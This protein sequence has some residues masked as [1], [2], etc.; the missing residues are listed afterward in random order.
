MLTSQASHR[1]D[2]VWQLI[3]MNKSYFVFQLEREE[4]E[5]LFGPMKPLSFMEHK[6]IFDE[7]GIDVDGTSVM[8][9]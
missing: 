6:Q 3:T 9:R 7:T 1:K 5:K 4:K 2:S 8:N